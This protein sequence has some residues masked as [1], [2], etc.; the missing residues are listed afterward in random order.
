[1]Q[2]QQL[3]RTCCFVECSL[4]TV[5]NPLTVERSVARHGD[6]ACTASATHTMASLEAK[7]AELQQL[8]AIEAMSSD[9]VAQLEHVSENFDSLSEGTKGA[10][11]GVSLPLRHALIQSL[12]QLWLMYW[13]AGTSC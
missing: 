13:G 3:F 2:A 4:C 1:M 9:L 6:P 10:H 11:A 8:Q 5:C 12:L 7:Q